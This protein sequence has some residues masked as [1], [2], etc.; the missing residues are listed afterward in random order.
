MSVLC[1]PIIPKVRLKSKIAYIYAWYWNIGMSWNFK[2]RCRYL[3][4]EMMKWSKGH[5]IHIVQTK[6]CE[7]VVTCIYCTTTPSV[8]TDSVQLCL[9]NICKGGKYSKWHFRGNIFRAD[10]VRFSE[11]VRAFKIWHYAN[12]QEAAF[13]PGKQNVFWLRVQQSYLGLDHLRDLYL[14]RL[15]WDSQVCTLWFKISY[16]GH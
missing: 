9:V 11:D 13:S 3:H 10:F 6:S 4:W 16:I 14:H 5:L 1:N 2:E 15:Q 12:F 8:C 7:V